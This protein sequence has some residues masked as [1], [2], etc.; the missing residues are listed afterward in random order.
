V[1][2]RLRRR[3]RARA[4]GGVRAQSGYT[5]IETMVAMT[6]MSV[7]IA[8]AFG[9]VS[10]MQRGAMLTTNRFTA[11]G[12]AQTISD[13]ITKDIRAA[14]TTSA[15][16]AAFA[17]AD[18][19]D[20][21]FYANLADPNGPTRLH[22]YLTL[23][24]GTNVYLFHEDST[25]P[26]AGGSTGNYTYTTA[27]QSR[28]DGKYIDTTQPIFSYYDADNNLIPT[29]ITTVAGLRSI[30]SVAINLRVRVSP[31]SPIIVMNAVVHIRNTDYNPNT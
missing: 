1:T 26:D 25:A 17:S 8:A 18:Q 22:A 13:R 7:V 31:N 12:E 28:I 10:A 21:T 24:P 16:G 30:D 14:V 19:N 4:R 29:P 15:S 23:Q 2:S 9:V 11:E 3:T 20:V 6:L 27:P 5:L